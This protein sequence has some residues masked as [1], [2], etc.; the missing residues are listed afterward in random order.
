[1][2]LA[3]ILDEGLY[4]LGVANYPVLE[5][6]ILCHARITVNSRPYQET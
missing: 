5:G 3:F 4:P 2:L 6:A 1:V